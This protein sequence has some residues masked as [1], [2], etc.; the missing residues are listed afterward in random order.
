MRRWLAILWMRVWMRA[1]IKCVWS[2]KACKS[3]FMGLLLELI[4]DIVERSGRAEGLMG[5]LITVMWRMAS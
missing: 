1:S 5:L 4:R 2:P 3:G